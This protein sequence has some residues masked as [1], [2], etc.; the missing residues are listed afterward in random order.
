MAGRAEAATEWSVVLPSWADELPSEWGW[1]RLADVC[2]DIVDCPH[3]TPELVEDGPYLMARTS[4]ILTGVFRADQARRVSEGTYRERT[5]RVEPEYGD[6]LYS[7]EGTYFGLAAEIPAETRVCLGQRMVLLRPDAEQVHPA[8]LRYWLNSSR[9]QSHIQGYRDG[10]VAER[11]NLP[12][13]RRLPVCTPSMWE[14]RAIAYILGTLD[15]K[16]ELNRRMNETLESIARVLFKSWFVDFDPVRDKAQGRDPGLPRSLADLFPDAFE[17]SELGEIPKGWQVMSLSDLVE[18]AYGRA[19]KEEVRKA[20]PVPVFGSNGQVGWHDEKLADG[21][22]IIVGR[23]GN[24]GIV[25]W[26]PSDFFCIDTTFYVV[27]R[28][29]SSSLHFLYY[30]L[31]AHDLASLGADSAVPGLNRNLAYMSRQLVPSPAVVDAFDGCVRR[32]FARRHHDD[33]QTRTLGALRDTLLPKLLSGEL[34]L[35]DAE[36]IVTGQV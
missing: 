8:Y 23:K 35:K 18:F 36:R 30:A 12:T 11:L 26:A 2:L 29:E 19:L 4:D 32:L 28:R 31:R 14:Q 13:I 25:T 33:E 22:G 1:C 17:D 7:R 20:G 9:I 10:S 5:R 3:S 24:P 15:E 6:L 16:I 34:R 27:P 21:P